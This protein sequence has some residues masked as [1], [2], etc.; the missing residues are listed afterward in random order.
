M[1]KDAEV[2]RSIPVAIKRE[3]RKRCC[4]GCVICG[5]PVW[6]YD[7]M[8]EF[9]TV[10]EHTAE[11]ITLLCPN[12]HQ[13]KTS[14][15]LS[16]EAVLRHNERPFSCSHERSAPHKMFFSAQPFTIRV[17]SMTYTVSSLPDSGE[18]PA[19]RF[20]G[21]TLVG[22][23]YEDGNLLLNLLQRDVLGNII[24]QIFKGELTVSTNL[25]DFEYIG[26]TLR[27]KPRF[28][29][30]LVFVQSADSID[31]QKGFFFGFGRTLEIQPDGLIVVQP[32]NLRIQGFM[33]TDCRIGL[34]V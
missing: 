13:E 26:P 23:I 17:G 25:G 24:L 22:F 34:E 9:A 5:A 19:I 20:C 11:N 2:S 32:M 15:R 7:H 6:H 28:S 3:V 27:I 8:E 12:H 30:E 18:F 16:K 14:R 31:I 33:T 10:N 1:E 29:S 4:F 21:E